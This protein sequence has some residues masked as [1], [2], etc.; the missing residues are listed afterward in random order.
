MVSPA[1]LQTNLS[2]FTFLSYSRHL[3]RTKVIYTRSHPIS[4][5]DYL[6]TNNT[7][8]QRG[9]IQFHAFLYHLIETHFLLLVDNNYFLYIFPNTN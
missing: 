2:Y 1:P 5:F 3:D 7:F 9:L 6:I 8:V 4:N